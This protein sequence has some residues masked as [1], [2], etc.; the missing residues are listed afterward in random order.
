MDVFIRGNFGSENRNDMYSLLGLVEA[1]TPHFGYDYKEAKI[2]AEMGL[3]VKGKFYDA[4]SILARKGKEL[5]DFLEMIRRVQ[6]YSA[7]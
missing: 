5:G 1:N 7:R 6:T 2:P 3:V 4:K